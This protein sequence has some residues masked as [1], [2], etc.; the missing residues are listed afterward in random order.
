MAPGNSSNAADK[1]KGKD[2]APAEPKKSTCLTQQA[3]AV[4][5]IDTALGNSARGNDA[6]DYSYSDMPELI[7]SGVGVRISVVPASSLPNDPEDPVRLA[8][9][10]TLDIP[11]DEYLSPD[12]EEALAANT[13]TEGDTEGED[14]LL[15][16]DDALTHEHI[17]YAM[18][19]AGHG[20]G[21]AE[22]STPA[23]NTGRR[24]DRTPA[25]SECP[26]KWTR[27]R[28][29]F[30]DLATLPEWGP[31][32]EELLQVRV[33]Q[34]VMSVVQATPSTGDDVEGEVDNTSES[35]ES[36]GEESGLVDLL[37]ALDIA[38]AYKLDNFDDNL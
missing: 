32:P 33:A 36:D 16:H 22:P 6:I 15:Q 29:D 4:L 28:L 11:E 21:F 34:I 35:D 30:G 27:E 7:T 9:G 31:S 38:H 12:T 25:T 13:L 18:E 3:S 23:A 5:D 1:R 14:E 20:S 17:A 2:K 37:D 26:A 24:T 10:S 19:F 8:T